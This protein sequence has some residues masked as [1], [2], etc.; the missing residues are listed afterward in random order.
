MRN[1]K[2]FTALILSGLIMALAAPAR[3]QIAYGQP[4]SGNLK[5]YYSHWQ[6]E[7]DSVT[8]DISQLSLPVN[9]FV[10][11]Q[12]NL[13]M[14][15][16]VANASN[17]IDQEYQA[18]STPDA[19]YS[20]SGL[21][22]MRLQ[23]NRAF[24]DDRFLFSLGLNLP[25]GKKS[26]SHEDEQPVMNVLTRNYLSFPIRRLGEG[27]GVNLMTGA[28]T[29]FGNHRLGATLTYQ[30]NGSYEAYEGDGDYSPG[31][32]FSLGINAETG[33]EN[34]KLFGNIAYTTF[35]TDQLEDRKVFKQ[36]NQL[37][38]YG[39][40]VYSGQTYALQ[41]QARYLVR[42]RNERYDENE[43]LD[44]RLKVY[45]NEFSLNGKYTYS[46]NRTWFVAPQMEL[47]FIAGNEFED[48]NA[49]GSASNIGF[50]A[51]YGRPIGEGINIGFGLIYYS[52]SADG[53]NIDLSG[54]RL[55]VGLTAAL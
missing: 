12:D 6:I 27:F 19:D 45:G 33:Q 3:S 40:M 20:L 46:P 43:I 48:A 25:T 1:R 14:R 47:R 9:A 50:G 39:G 38:L 31:N 41:G 54:Y 53:G 21:S 4:T 51:E 8:T 28:A 23:L 49:S 44:Y 36:S 30:F 32:M 2:L 11:L 18:A 35:G 5:L 13:E 52:G 17:N 16:F 10:P 15:L 42:G 24:S 29:S 26:L 37:E 34:W 22:D 55:S 7:N